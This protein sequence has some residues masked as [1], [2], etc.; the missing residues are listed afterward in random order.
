MFGMVVAA[1]IKVLSNV[2]YQ[3]SDDAS[4][5]NLIIVAVS[6]VVGM[7]PLVN[8]QL[9]SQMPEWMSPFTHSGIVLA[10]VTSLLLNLYLNGLPK[11]QSK[12]L[13]ETA[14]RA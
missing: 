10:A 8:K 4:R 2:S 5:N 1:G 11:A 3:D 14:A 13:H 7:M 9:F 6:V 12:E